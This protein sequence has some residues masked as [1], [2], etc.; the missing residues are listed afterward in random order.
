M[1]DPPCEAADGKMRCYRCTKQDDGVE[2]ACD[3][4]CDHD[5]D[6]TDEACFQ[7]EP[8]AD[9]N[10]TTCFKC[11]GTGDGV[12]DTCN[13]LCDT[14]GDGVANA[15]FQHDVDGDGH[16]DSCCATF[17]IRLE[18]SAEFAG[19]SLSRV[20]IDESGTIEVFG[21]NGSDGPDPGDLVWSHKGEVKW[22]NFGT[23]WRA[24][25]EAG[26]F[27]ICAEDP[28]SG[29]KTCLTAEVVVPEA[30]VMYR[31]PN[32]CLKHFE[33]HPT[34]GFLAFW[35]LTPSDVSFA[36]IETQEGGGTTVADG[37]FKVFN[38]E[39][40]KTGGVGKIR[41]GR[42]RQRDSSRRI[43]RQGIR[44]R[45]RAGGSCFNRQFAYAYS[46]V[47]PRQQCCRQERAIHRGQSCRLRRCW[48]CDQ[49]QRRTF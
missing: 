9:G 16:N 32:T 3:Y 40:H 15:C 35:H 43:R 11:D 4:T 39:E 18:P 45:S 23:L 2:N 5:G 19:R 47:V 48:H 22:R 17:G 25:D 12:K 33:G 41:S 24:G 37:I 42:G 29:C 21:P 14:T 38:G 46:V 10:K 31:I 34:C 27:T 8:D 1:I 44:W 20:G 30:V 26:S 13:S 7:C 49:K 36:N 28:N 6:G